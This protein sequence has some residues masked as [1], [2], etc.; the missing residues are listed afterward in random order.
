MIFDGTGIDLM[1][2]T[3]LGANDIR[4]ITA[5]DFQREVLRNTHQTEPASL[6]AATFGMTAAS[7]IFSPRRTTFFVETLSSLT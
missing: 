5:A 4:I 3:C 2:R 7:L 1:V 6:T